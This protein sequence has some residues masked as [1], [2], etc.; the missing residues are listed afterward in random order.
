MN[1]SNIGKKKIKTKNETIIKGIKQHK[2]QGLIQPLQSQ[3]YVQSQS[4]ISQPPSAEELLKRQ[5]QK[6]EETQKL[7]DKLFKTTRNLNIN[8]EKIKLL[9][10]KMEEQ[11]DIHFY[12]AELIQLGVFYDENKGE[13]NIF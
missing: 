8:K 10:L 9:Q 7:K 4:I 11:E 13:D 3:V 2:S 1:Y 5:Q 12:K 6:E